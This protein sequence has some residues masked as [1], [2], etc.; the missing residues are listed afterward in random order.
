LGHSSALGGSTLDLNTNDSGSLSFDSV[1]AATLGGLAGGRDVVLTN[2][3]GAAV[4]LTVGNNNSNTAYLGVLSG[5]GGF[6]K[7]GTGTFAW[8]T[9]RTPQ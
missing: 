7:T 5:A 1:T 3:S 4:T 2:A 6:A 8:G 9:A